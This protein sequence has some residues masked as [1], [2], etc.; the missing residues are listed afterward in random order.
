ML[1]WG[2]ICRAEQKYMPFFGTVTKRAFR[3][4][5]SKIVP[6]FADKEFVY[7]IMYP[8]NSMAD[9]IEI[10]I[11]FPGLTACIILEL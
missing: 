4:K 2:E 1:L 10:W 7:G 3:K 11:L 8:E 5:N 6:G 9:G